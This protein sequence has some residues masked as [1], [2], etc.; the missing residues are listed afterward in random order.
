MMS[1]M[2]FK[3]NYLM[4][5]TRCFLCKVKKKRIH[6]PKSDYNINP[7]WLQPRIGVQATFKKPSEYQTASKK[8]K[9]SQPRHSPCH[10]PANL[11]KWFP[12]KTQP[13][14]KGFIENHYFFN[15]CWLCYCVNLCLAFNL[16]WGTCDKLKGFEQNSPVKGNPFLQG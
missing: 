12:N 16:A 4:S 13:P 6:K 1:I 11:A 9:T 7:S 10:W 5:S 3:L 2:V 8:N 14:S 15:G